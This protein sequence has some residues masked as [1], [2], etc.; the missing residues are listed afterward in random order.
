M[1]VLCVALFA[2]F[3]SSLLAAAPSTAPYAE[4]LKAS[5]SS[6]KVDY[7][8]VTA[9]RAKLDA[10]LKAVAETDAKT[11]G[12]DAKAFYINAYNA[13]VLRAVLTQQEKGPLKSVLDV[14]GFFDGLKYR[15]AGEELT[16]NELEEKRLRKAFNDP[17]IHFAVNCASASCP[18][19]QPEP[20]ST[21]TLDAKLDEATRAYFA[22]P[23]G[24]R[25][26]KEGV[27]VTKLLEWYEGDFGGKPGVKAFLVKYAPASM[28]A[29]VEKGPIAF[30][31][32]DWALN[33]K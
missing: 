8:K 22:T 24:M 26:A 20:F 4:V 31:D 19:L 21:S 23:H 7:A 28:K 13:T 17:R 12:N 15:V 16:L 29:S 6:G 27:T 5:V 30:H 11:L 3:P 1:R 33:A 32:Y 18:V 9:E 14:K 25:A 10:Y 2:L